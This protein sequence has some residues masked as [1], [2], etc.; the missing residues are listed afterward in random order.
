MYVCVCN[1]YRES[2]IRDAARAG[3]RCARRVYQSLGSGPQC[4]K[5]L[6]H[7]QDLIDRTQEREQ[8]TPLPA[9]LIPALAVG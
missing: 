1:G 3:V 7:A 8:A 4:G 5:C 6:D 2:E 9:A